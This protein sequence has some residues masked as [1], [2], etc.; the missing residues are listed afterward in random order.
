MWTKWAVA[1]T[2]KVSLKGH[3]AGNR[4]RGRL[5]KRWLENIKHFCEEADMPSVAAAGHLCSKEQR[6]RETHS[7]EAISETY[8]Y[9]W[10]PAIM[11]MIFQP[12][13]IWWFGMTLMLDWVRMIFPFLFI[14]NQTG[15]VTFFIISRMRNNWWLLHVV[16]VTPCF[17]S[18]RENT[19]R[20]SVPVA[21]NIK[22]T[23]FWCEEELV[24]MCSQ[25]WDV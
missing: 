20:S 22:S 14:T 4:P 5:G 25:L 19:G 21:E 24:E 1:D 17:K 13:T 9:L 8:M 16:H 6:P 10:K 3:N 18:L 2:P 11:M 12:I 7:W 23:T 15:M